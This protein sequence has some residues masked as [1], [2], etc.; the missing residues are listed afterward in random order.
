MCLDYCNSLTTAKGDCLSIVTPQTGYMS[1]S[2]TLSHYNLLLAISKLVLP[3]PPRYEEGVG[4][5]FDPLTSCKHGSVITLLVPNEED[6]V[7]ES[8][9]SPTV[10]AVILVW[11]GVICAASASPPL[12]HDARPIGCRLLCKRQLRLHNSFVECDQ[13]QRARL[14]SWHTTC[15]RLWPRTSMEGFW[16]FS[17]DGC[18]IVLC[19]TRAAFISLTYT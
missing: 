2:P 1:P 6:G 12:S 3:L 5:L 17:V 9:N 8:C 7:R 14:G 13:L 18:S 19:L 11:G 4:R 15:Q 16:V 10:S